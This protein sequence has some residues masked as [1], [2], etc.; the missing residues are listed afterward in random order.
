MAIFDL[1]KEYLSLDDVLLVPK[2]S[3]IKSRLDT[4][5]STILVPDIKLK[6]PVVSAA[7][8]TISGPTMAIKLGRLGGAAFLHRFASDEEIVSW[9]K[10]IKEAKQVAI[11]SIGV[12]PDVVSWVGILLSAGAD[13]VSIDIAHAHSKH[14]IE[15]VRLLKSV[16]KDECKIVAGNVATREGVRDLIE[17]GADCVKIFIGSGAACSTRIVTGFGFPTFS[18]LVECID[19]ADR[20][21]IPVIADGGLKTP[22]DFTK[23]LAVGVRACMSGSMLSSTDETPGK[24]VKIGGKFYKEYRGMA[25]EASQ[26]DFK[27]GLKSGTASEG[28]AMLFEA[29]GPVK[30][31][32]DRI[33]G[34]IRSGLTYCGAKNLQELRSNAHFIRITSSA[35]I[36]GTPHGLKGDG[37]L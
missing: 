36:E 27:D 34:G 4:D 6:I 22:G 1:D 21:G 8:D 37:V 7:M 29:R 18:C 11:P 32:I 3:E 5:I 14:V 16:Y 35:Y 20:H 17:A 25:S 15:T 31:I 28:E 24:Y 26:K 2:Y 10:D 33:V 13:V 9:V 23:C 12:R 19:E 30:D